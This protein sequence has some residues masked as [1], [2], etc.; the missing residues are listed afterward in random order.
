MKASCKRQILRVL[1]TDRLGPR[2][3]SSL[4]RRGVAAALNNPDNTVRSNAAVALGMI[5][6]AADG[7]VLALTAA[8]NDPDETVRQC[9]TE[10]LEWIKDK[11]TS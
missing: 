11:T 6:P 1:L 5:G 4:S 7:A 8:L 10:A 2:R 3:L 9:G